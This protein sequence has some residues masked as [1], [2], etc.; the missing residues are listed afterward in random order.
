MALVW[1]GYQLGVYKEVTRKD[2][3]RGPPVR[4]Q[5]SWSVSFFVSEIV[6]FPQVRP[7]DSHSL[8]RVSRV[9]M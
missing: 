3:V 7:Q 2:F 1:P 4:D 6:S 9:I 5:G 8:L